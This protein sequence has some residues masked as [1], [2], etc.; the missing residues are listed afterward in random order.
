MTAGLRVISRTIVQYGASVKLGTGEWAVVRH[1]AQTFQHPCPVGFDN[2][3]RRAARFESELEI[4]GSLDWGTTRCSR[5][6]VA[7]IL[8]LQMLCSH[9]HQRREQDLHFELRRV[10][11]G[12]TEQRERLDG[13]G[14]LSQSLG[15]ARFGPPSSRMGAMHP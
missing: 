11:D 4:G 1:P 13:L 3:G 6:P 15:N 5:A 12:L 14:V 7:A 8:P 10:I 9:N 2:I